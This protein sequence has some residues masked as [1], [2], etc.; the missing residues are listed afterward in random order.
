MTNVHALSRVPKHFWIMLLSVIVA[1]WWA[2]RAVAPLFLLTTPILAYVLFR[3][4]VRETRERLFDEAH[5]LDRLPRAVRAR[6]LRALNQL[7]DGETRDLLT[8]IVQVGGTARSNLPQEYARGDFGHTID[9]LV[10]A[11]AETAVHAQ[12]LERTLHTLEAQ[13]A[14]DL[15]LADALE[16]VR[17]AR[18]SRVAQLTTALRV[19]S[20]V[21]PD[22]ADAGD[23]GSGRIVEILESLEREVSAHETAESEIAHLLEASSTRR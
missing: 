15:D 13:P 16:R 3:A 19:L 1:G 10:S 12:S 6:A 20:E 18:S 23:A 9:E 4:Q 5:G 8:G 22:I 14:H 11:A 2:G 17:E 21:G 7:T